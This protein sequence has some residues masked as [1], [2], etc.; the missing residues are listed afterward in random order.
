MLDLKDVFYFVQVV[1]KGGYTAA[2]KSLGFPKSTL[3]HRIRALED[4]LGV[5]LLSRTSHRFAVTEVGTQFYHYAQTLLQAAEVAEEAVRQRA[6]EPSGVIRMTTAVE[7]AQFALKE[8]IPGF[9][10][11][12]P[13]VRIVVNTTDALVD[14]VAHGFDLALRGHNT[15]LQNSS[16]VQRTIA[17]APWYLFAG[18]DYLSARG[19]PATPEEIA[20]HDTL[21][22]AKSGPSNWTLTGPNDR[23][24]IVQI[25]PRLQS[26]NMVALKEAAC[27]NLGI[28]AL[29][30]YICRDELASGRLTQILPRWTAADARIS[31]LI[32]YK[33]GV[34]PAVRSLVDF[35][36]REMPRLT[37]FDPADATPM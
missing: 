5:T 35:F 18:E 6:T 20:Q 31:A 15:S 30:G 14:I 28:V 32:P 10:R 3:S 9:L 13:Q 2:S 34:L 36:A 19:V 16:L 37:A 17:R 21:A 4:A 7:I 25:T 12:H 23:R 26:N 22:I 8:L 24:C 1:D 11:M 29:P 27:A 33:R